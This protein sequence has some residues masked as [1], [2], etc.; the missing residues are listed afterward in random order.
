MATTTALTS[1]AKHYEHPDLKLKFK[2]N[3]QINIFSTLKLTQKIQQHSYVC[4]KWSQIVRKVFSTENQ[5]Q[6]KKIQTR[7]ERIKSI[8]N[9]NFSGYPIPVRIWFSC[10]TSFLTAIIII[11][12]NY[13]HKKCSS[14]S[15]THCTLNHHKLLSVTLSMWI[16]IRN[17]RKNNKYEINEK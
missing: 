9:F 2:K 7:H 4:M 17:K 15:L 13:T 8:N 3:K 5:R 10:K 6:T 16:R 1:D 11:I 14:H 12:C